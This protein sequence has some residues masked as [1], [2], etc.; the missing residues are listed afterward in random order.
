MVLATCHTQPR[1]SDMSAG[2]IDVGDFTA[3]CLVWLVESHNGARYFQFS[4]IGSKPCSPIRQGAA[5]TEAV[6]P[7]L[8]RWILQCL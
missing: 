4:P 1:R 8:I 2:L 3:Y 5:S 7:S 6:I